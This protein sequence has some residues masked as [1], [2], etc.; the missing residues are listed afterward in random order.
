MLETHKADRDYQGETAADETIGNQQATQAE[1]GWLAGIIDGEGHIGIS[2]QNR[3]VSRSVSVDLQIVNTD[4][5]LTDRVVEIMNKLGVNP[6]V[7]DRVHNKK[8]WSTNRIICLRKFA[9]VMRILDAVEDNLTGITREKARLM[10][11]LI[12]SRMQKTRFDR[13][14]EYELALVDDFRSRFIGLCGAS[15]TARKARANMAQ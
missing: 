8:T 11:L 9:S 14:D 4:F 6:Y 3:K 2:L 12:E 5:A 13:Y 1:I 10:R 7:R 15:T